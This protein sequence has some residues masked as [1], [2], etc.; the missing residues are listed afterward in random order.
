MS[1][2]AEKVADLMQLRKPRQIDEAQ[3][4]QH[5]ERGAKA[6]ALLR[7]DAFTSAFRE[8]A[9]VYESAWRNTAP[10]DVETR[11]RAWVALRLLDDL[12]NQ[13]IST[14]RDGVVAQREIEKSLRQ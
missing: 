3:A 5:R 12:R 2:I 8:V 10:L 11:E 1:T 7:D 14:V 13:L 4:R 6:E 9:Q